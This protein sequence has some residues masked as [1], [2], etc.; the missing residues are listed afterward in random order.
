MTKKDFKKVAEI[1]RK[2]I[3]KSRDELGFDAAVYLIDEF[4]YWFEDENP[5]FDEKKFRQ[6]VLD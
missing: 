2:M 6:A 1:L 3:E 4:S 5:N